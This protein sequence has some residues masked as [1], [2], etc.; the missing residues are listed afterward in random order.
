[1]HLAKGP[2]A[3]CLDA[4]PLRP[5]EAIDAPAE[6]ASVASRVDASVGT[7]AFSAPH[8]QFIAHFP[9]ERVADFIDSRSHRGRRAPEGFAEH[10][11]RGAE[12]VVPT[13]A[14]HVVLASWEA[15]EDRPVREGA[16]VVGLDKVLCRIARQL[17]S[18]PICHAWRAQEDSRDKSS[19]GFDW[20]PLTLR[21]L[22]ALP[23]HRL[24]AGSP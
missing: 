20:L 24:T 1:M 10:L 5:T 9:A 18:L 21:K 4:F 6:V 3:L 15:R 17:Q 8:A 2:S 16:E 11:V 14:V 7:R 23:R 19:C 13:L 12:V 22:S